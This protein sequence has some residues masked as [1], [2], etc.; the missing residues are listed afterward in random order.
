M[1]RGRELNGCIARI[2]TQRRPG[3]FHGKAMSGVVCLN[4]CRL[5][6]GVV[7]AIGSAHFWRGN[8]AVVTLRG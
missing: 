7:A 4:G 1:S 3:N 2:E 5:R 8:A 6:R